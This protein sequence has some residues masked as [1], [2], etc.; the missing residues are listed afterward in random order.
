MYT[1]ERMDIYLI[2]GEGKM[3]KGIGLFNGK[4]NLNL[5]VSLE[6]DLRI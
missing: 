6:Q 5:E 3:Q 1:D 4:L 2:E